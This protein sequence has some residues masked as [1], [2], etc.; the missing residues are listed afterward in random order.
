MY[1]C[2]AV[3][4][5]VVFIVDFKVY[6]HY[7]F[8]LKFNCNEFDEKPVFEVIRNWSIFRLRS[9]VC[10]GTLITKKSGCSFLQV[11]FLYAGSY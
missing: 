2:K 9:F 3:P 4:H 7:Y 8:I 11:S 5:V 1:F 6:A 10:Q